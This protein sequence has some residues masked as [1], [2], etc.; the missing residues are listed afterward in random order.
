MLLL[1][2]VLIALSSLVFTSYLFFAPAKRNFYISYGLVGLTLFSGTI[3]VLSTHSPILASCVTG[4][5]YIGVVL[6]GIVGA[7]HRLASSTK[8]ID[9]TD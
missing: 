2:H 9:K 1:A 4:L 6:I 5:V 8:D 7:R 3:L